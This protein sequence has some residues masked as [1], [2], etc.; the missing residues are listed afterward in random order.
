V[1]KLA[2]VIKGHDHHDQTAQRID[3]CIT[4]LPGREVNGL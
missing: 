1:K 2:R 3:G 4:V